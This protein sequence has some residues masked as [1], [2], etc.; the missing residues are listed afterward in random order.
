VNYELGFYI[1]ADGILLRH[2]LEHL[3]SYTFFLTPGDSERA[4]RFPGLVV[5][6]M[7]D[8][9]NGEYSRMQP[10]IMYHDPISSKSIR[11]SHR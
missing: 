2:R 8:V 10:S 7:Y 5:N 9:V 4:D 6:E 3:K 1:P 11:I